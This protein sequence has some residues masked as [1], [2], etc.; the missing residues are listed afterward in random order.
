MSENAIF[1]KFQQAWPYILYFIET[2]PLLSPQQIFF[3]NNTVR[4]CIG[5]STEHMGIQLILNMP[6]VFKK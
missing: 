1:Q 5:A 6:Q 4:S 3:E 2:T